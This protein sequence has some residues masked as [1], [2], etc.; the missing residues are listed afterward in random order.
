VCFVRGHKTHCFPDVSVNKCFVLFSVLLY[1][2]SISQVVASSNV[3]LYA[4]KY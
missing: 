3:E 1:F 4:S 2:F